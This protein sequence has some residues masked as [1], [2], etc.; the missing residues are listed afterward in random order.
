VANTGQVVP[1]G[2][3]ARLFAPFQRLGPSRNGDG[4]R[5]G[6]GLGLSIVSAIA[7]AHQADLEGRALPGGGLDVRLRF[8]QLPA[9]LPAASACRG[10]ADGGS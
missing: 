2:E 10:G 8:R 7:A 3:V 9:G 5:D 1:P 6:Q 4:R